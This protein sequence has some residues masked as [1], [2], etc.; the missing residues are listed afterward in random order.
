[1]MMKE[2]KKLKIRAE[3]HQASLPEFSLLAYFFI[4]DV[5]IKYQKYLAPGLFS[6]ISI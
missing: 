1:M 6:R 2:G 5:S 4:S 3:I